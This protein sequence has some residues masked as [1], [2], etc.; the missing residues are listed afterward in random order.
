V[1]KAWD[2]AWETMHSIEAATILGRDFSRNRK[3]IHHIKKYCEIIPMFS[4][5]YFLL[6]SILRLPFWLVSPFGFIIR[7]HVRSLK[8][9]LIPEIERRIA[10]LDS[11]DEREFAL[12]NALLTSKPKPMNAGQ[13]EQCAEE[14]C[15]MT[16]EGVGPMT[17]LLMQLMYEIISKPAYLD[18]LRN[19]IS[20]ALQESGGW[21]DEALKLMPKLESFT[22]ETLRL[23][24]P[25]PC[26]FADKP[27]IASSPNANTT[28]SNETQ[29]Q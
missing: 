10:A 9:L 29:S 15:F 13:I 18:D 3:Y 24:G 25:A 11:G 16:F 22:R 4:F 28:A 26:K 7:H 5:F 19:E 23:N 6:P 21:S 17:L 27:P 1:N 14:L 2:I 12:I 20:T 8:G